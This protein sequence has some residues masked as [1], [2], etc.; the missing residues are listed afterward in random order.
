MAGSDF[1]DNGENLWIANSFVNSPLSVY[2]KDGEWKSFYCG[3]LAVDQ[4]CT[5]LI[6]D[7][8]YG[9]I[10]M[11]IKGVGVLVYDYNQTPLDESDDQY[12]IIGTGSGSGSLPS[13]YV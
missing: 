6:F 11:V 4:L 1:D 9:Y 8:I 12:Q 2:T 5:D 7:H 13:S 3:S 10:W